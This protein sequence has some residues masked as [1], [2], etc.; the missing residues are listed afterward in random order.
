MK[1]FR[2]NAFLTIHY[3]ADVDCGTLDEP[4]HGT[5]SLENGKTTYA[6]KAIYT[7]NENYTLVGNEVRMC[8]SEGKWSNSKPK[9]SFNWCPDP[10]PVHGGLV[11]ATGH[12]TGDTAKY[13]CYPGYIIFGEEVSISIQFRKLKLI[14]FGNVSSCSESN[15]I[16]E[17]KNE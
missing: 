9:C 4:E 11:T 2:N 15:S 14:K 10:P 17:I 16:V 12:H 13:E 6:S 5:I 8:E 1:Q 7:C 3:F